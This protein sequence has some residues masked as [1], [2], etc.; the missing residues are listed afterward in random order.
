[1]QALLARQQVIWPR[2]LRMHASGCGCTCG[3]MH[4]LPPH[5]L[6]AALAQELLA[7]FKGSF[8]KWVDAPPCGSC[9][10]AATAG[11]GM[12]APTADEAAHGAGRVEVYACRACGAGTRFPRYN[13]PVKLLETRRGRCGE[14][15]NCFTLCCR[16]V[17]W[18]VWRAGG[19]AYM[20]GRL[21]YMPARPAHP[22][23]RHPR[24]APAL[25][26]PS[27]RAAGLDA[28][29]AVDLEDHVWT[30]AW[31]EAQQKWWVGGWV[32]GRVCLNTHHWSL[33]VC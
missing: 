7:W 8:F 25:S 21:L 22:T 29:L 2:K 12:G 32:G 14:W 4:A 28:R 13:D 9:G 20:Y 30:E 16:S 33:G 23:W 19:G 24:P 18:G 26:T 1:M 3:G 6:S 10:A 17:C 31:S 15:A 27:S 5:S 11:A